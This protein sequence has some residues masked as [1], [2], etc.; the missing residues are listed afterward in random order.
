[1]AYMRRSPVHMGGLE[2]RLVNFSV[3]GMVCALVRIDKVKVLGE[4]DILC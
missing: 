1:M 2:L 3:K 4:R